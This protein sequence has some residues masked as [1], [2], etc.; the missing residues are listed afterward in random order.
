M[1]TFSPIATYR[2]IHKIP[3]I[4]SIRS[5]GVSLLLFEGEGEGDGEGESV[6]W[7]LYPHGL[8]EKQ[9]EQSVFIDPEASQPGPQEQSQL[10]EPAAALVMNRVKKRIKSLKGMLRNERWSRLHC[11]EIVVITAIENRRSFRSKKE[12]AF[13]FYFRR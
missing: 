8:C 6:Q 9:K 2:R 7:A 12:H 1:A 3:L 4:L 13:L 5:C 10:Q 11:D